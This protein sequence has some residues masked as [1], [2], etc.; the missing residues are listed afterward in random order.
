MHICAD[1][2]H[3]GEHTS[4]YIQCIFL[5]LSV[6]MFMTEDQIRRLQDPLS[7]SDKMSRYVPNKDIQFGYRIR[8]ASGKHI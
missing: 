2:S 5:L 1:K 8:S 4:S 7:E 6:D 3:V